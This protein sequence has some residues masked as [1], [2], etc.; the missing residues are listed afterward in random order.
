VKTDQTTWVTFPYQ[1][2]LRKRGLGDCCMRLLPLWPEPPIDSALA[3]CCSGMHLADTWQFCPRRE[4][5]NGQRAKEISTGLTCLPGNKSIRLQDRLA[6]TM[7]TLM[8]LAFWHLL[9]ES[10]PCDAVQALWDLSVNANMPKPEY[11]LEMSFMIVLPWTLFWLCSCGW[12][13]GRLLT[14]RCWNQG[15]AMQAQTGNST[16]LR[17]EMWNYCLVVADFIKKFETWTVLWHHRSL[18]H[19]TLLLTPT[20]H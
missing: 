7:D 20:Y 4:K 11:S 14:V 12:Q 18:K 9:F 8:N 17:C 5:N 16:Q 3:L 1:G 6:D 10:A 13:D 19:N 15:T 2:P